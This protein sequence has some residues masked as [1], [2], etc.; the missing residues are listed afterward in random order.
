ML[1]L[2]FIFNL[3]SIEFPEVTIDT[4]AYNKESDN[5]EEFYTTLRNIKNDPNKDI[6]YVSAMTDICKTLSQLTSQTYALLAQMK[7]ELENKPNEF[8]IQHKKQ[9]R[10]KSK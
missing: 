5:I 10:L 1:K 4:Q 3:I 9:R 6:N 7:D 2:D 8:K